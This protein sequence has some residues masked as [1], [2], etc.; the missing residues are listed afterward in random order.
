MDVGVV[1]SLENLRNLILETTPL[2]FKQDIEWFEKGYQKCQS[3]ILNSRSS[4]LL[5][6]IFAIYYYISGFDDPHFNI[7]FKLYNPPFNSFVFSY[8]K[9]LTNYSF[10]SNIVYV[11]FSQDPNIV[12]GSIITK[13]NDMP[14]MTYLRHA[15]LYSP[16]LFSSSYERIIAS[17]ELFIDQ[18]NPYFKRPETIQ[19]NNKKKVSL[20]YYKLPPG[21]KIYKGYEF[22]EDPQNLRYYKK[23]NTLYIKINYFYNLNF[24]PL[25]KLFPISNIIVDLRDNPGGDSQ[26]IYNFYKNLYKIDINGNEVFKD[27]DYMT[28]IFPIRKK[29]QTIFIRKFKKKIIKSASIP[30][31]TIYYGNSFSACQIFIKLAQLYI[32]KLKLIGNQEGLNNDRV[33]GY[34]NRTENKLYSLQLPTACLFFDDQKENLIQATNY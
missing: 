34:I 3:M 11:D 33:F 31:L 2:V 30:S 5:S 8:P 10:N 19:I 29:K 7:R 4:K 12:P 32:K 13:I 1:P 14:T 9:F 27:S 15:M 20:E 22:C 24:Y 17:Q 16:Y 21:L 6:E 18:G 25:T 28:T 23:D 26:S